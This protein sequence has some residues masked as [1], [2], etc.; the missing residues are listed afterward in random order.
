M[1]V[2]GFKGKE[3]RNFV[4]PEEEDLKIRAIDLLDK[5]IEPKYYLKKKGFEFVTSSKNRGRAKINSEIIRTEKRNQQF[6]WNGDFRFEPIDTI[7]NKEILSTAYIGTYNGQ[8]GVARKLTPREC[9]R[10]MG[11]GEDFVINPNDVDAYKQSGNSI[12]VNVIE[13]IK[14]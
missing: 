8:V 4:F 3:K 5:K 12:V 1:F 6:N 11:F 7:M 10:F 9:H 13:K 2:I 14:K